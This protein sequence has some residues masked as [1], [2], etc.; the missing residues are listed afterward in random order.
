[1]YGPRDPR[2]RLLEP[3][4]AYLRERVRAC[5]GLSGRR[6]YRDLMVLGYRGG[7]TAVTDYLRTVRSFPRPPFERRFETAPGEQAQVDFAEFSVVFTDHPDVRQKVWLFAFVLGNSRWL[8]GRFCADQRLDT[9]LRCHVMA[10]EA[11]GGAPAEIL[12]D[13][14]KTAVLGEDAAGTVTYNP[15]LV[16]L[17]RHYGVAPRA[18][19]AYRAKTKGKVERPFRYVRQD[20][21]LGRSFRNPEDL[22]AQYA[23]WLSG[24]ANARVHGTTNRV[25]QEAFEEERSHL[26]PLPQIP[27]DAVLDVKRQVTR[28]GMVSVSGNLYSVPD[29]TR[30]RRVE[31]QKHPRQLRIFEDGQLIARHLV[32]EG[33]NQRS[34]DPTHRLVP[35]QEDALP[36][37]AQSLREITIAP[38]PLAF[39]DAVAQRIASGETPK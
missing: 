25:V 5:E 22:N 23:A 26:I 2:P 14:M 31:V 35:P 8:W 32:L 37:T 1:M 29:A 11:C 7:Y 30:K 9:V 4:E 13:R 27:Y 16:A 17:L 3:Y 10:F 34:V 39:Y 38:R 36:E 28:D 12:Y 20:F 24:I 18:C 21:F 15:S 33:R 6:L 19:R